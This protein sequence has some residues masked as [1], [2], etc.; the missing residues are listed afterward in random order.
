M[1][2]LPLFIFWFADE[3]AEGEVKV[4]DDSVRSYLNSIAK[5]NLTAVARFVSFLGSPL[6]LAATGSLAAVALYLKRKRAEALLF[7]VTMLGEIAMSFLLK[8]W[9]RRM[10][11][12][13]FFDYPLPDSYSY[14]SGHAFG[15]FCFYGILAWIVIN[16]RQPTWVRIGVGIS[17]VSIIILI[18]ISRIYLGVHFP[19]DVIAGLIAGVSWVGMVILGYWMSGRK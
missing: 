3:I 18:G 2:A 1:L 16:S 14:P 6:F 10:R 8:A 13:T 7:A 15:S 19:S 9:F 12:D 5:P 11:P 17:T 4:F